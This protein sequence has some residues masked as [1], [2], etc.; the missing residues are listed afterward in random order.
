MECMGTAARSGRSSS[1]RTVARAG[2]GIL[3]VAERC[4]M[5]MVYLTKSQ[6]AMRALWLALPCRNCG[7]GIQAR[8][9][10]FKK[11][12]DAERLMAKWAS[13]TH[14]DSNPRARHARSCV[15]TTAPTDR[16]GQ[17]RAL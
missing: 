16:A 9:L 17:A 3:H 2:V 1:Y 11:E 15:L 4:G 5:V 10:A 6:Q 8:S 14:R 7:C 13:C 12:A